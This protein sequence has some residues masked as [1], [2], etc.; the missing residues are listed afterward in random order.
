MGLCSNPLARQEICW[1]SRKHTGEGESAT[2]LVELSASKQTIPTFHI[3]LGH[4]GGKP[5]KTFLVNLFVG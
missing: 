4:G 2:M 5:T 3:L 1:Q